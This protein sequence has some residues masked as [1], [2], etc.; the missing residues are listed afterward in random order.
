MTVHDTALAEAMQQLGYDTYSS[1]EQ[2]L[3]I[4]S[5]L[6][7]QDV[8]AIMPTGGGKTAGAILP[9]MVNGWA[10]LIVSPLKALMHD[11]CQGLKDFGLQAH[12]VNGDTSEEEFR[13][14]FHML[15]QPTGGPVFVF[16]TP[17]TALTV[18][19]KAAVSRVSFDLMMV[20]EV[21]CV[22]VW[23]GGFR[24]KYRRV[25][26]IWHSLDKPQILAVSATA[27]PHI[28][29]DV[30]SSIPFRK[31]HY[32]E[33]IGDPIRPNLHV[34]VQHP[35]S[36]LKTQAKVKDYFLKELKAYLENNHIPSHGP[37]I[38]YCT[39]I[40][41]AETLFTQLVGTADAN[42]YTI[43]LYHGELDNDHRKESLRI[44]RN[45]K[46]PLVIATSAFGMGID[47]D[48]VRTIVHYGPP[49]D[50]VEFAQQIGRSGRDGG[51]AYCWTLYM[52]WMVE[53]KRKADVG[54]VPTLDDVE[55]V[56]AMLRRTWDKAVEKQQTQFHL[57]QFHFMHDE[58]LKRQ[59]NVRSPGFHME[60][61][62]AS[63]Q[64]LVAL[65]YI[66]QVGD[67]I[68]KVGSMQFATD[69]HNKLI[70]LTEM[71]AR[72]AYRDAV[73]LRKF[74]EAEVPD[75]HLLFAIIAEE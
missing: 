40:R 56:Y 6:D 37:T 23:G 67:H 36:E 35:P 43:A 16:T 5:V 29:A 69:T 25:K 20:D 41:E 68:T 59:V 61:R 4:R 74:F 54:S 42:G 60:M 7:G 15:Q 2:E 51:I 52:P 19:F 12:V 58:W 27:D 72:K 17:E 57:D 31:T 9:A 1:P 13:D 26:S 71:K 3:M 11:Q 47:R 21:H 63:I 48:D 62:R 34:Y 75:Q 53:R 18:K 28:I 55:K 70:E 44:F 38:I 8:L 30:K 22:S 49:S 33:I 66:S 32:V 14:I 46:K 24:E 65:G 73:R 50:L 45:S 64:M 10:V 39:R